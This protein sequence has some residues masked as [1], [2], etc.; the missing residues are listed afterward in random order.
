M[1]EIKSSFDDVKCWL[2]SCK[3]GKMEMIKLT[4][5]LIVFP[6]FQLFRIIRKLDMRIKF[7]GYLDDKDKSLVYKNFQKIV[8]ILFEVFLCGIHRKTILPDIEKINNSTWQYPIPTLALKE[9]NKTRRTW[10]AQYN[11]REIDK[12]IFNYEHRLSMNMEVADVP[13]S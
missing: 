12:L 6:E 1:V 8:I 11:N 13:P 10:G 7:P 2:K 5:T 9:F 3:I 4:T